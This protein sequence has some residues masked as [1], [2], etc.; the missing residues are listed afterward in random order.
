MDHIKHVDEVLSVLRSAGV[1]LK[2][3]KCK[4]FTNAVEYLGHTIRP[5]RLEIDEAH[6]KALK[7]AKPPKTKS[8]LQ[9]FLGLANVYRRFVRGFTNIAAPLNRL[10][11]NGMPDKLEGFNLE[12]QKAFENLKRAV[13]TPPVLRLPRRGLPYVVDTDASNYQLGATLFQKHDDDKLYPIGYWSLTLNFHD[14]KYSTTE[15]EC[16][17]IVWAL[18]TLRPYLAGEELTVVT[19]HNALR[20]LLTVSEPSG[21]THAMETAFGGISLCHPIS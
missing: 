5:G 1:S 18:Q 17:A 10:L 12:E 16:L 14:K 8:A 9:F 6:T 7:E 19:D 4:F 11:K 15:K 21:T 20:W 13:T 2:L 3:K